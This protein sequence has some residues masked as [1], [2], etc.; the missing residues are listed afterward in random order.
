MFAKRRWKWTLFC[1]TLGGL[2]F[3]FFKILSISNIV[4]IL[5]TVHF[6]YTKLGSFCNME[7]YFNQLVY[8]D[9]KVPK[10][11]VG[12][13][14]MLCSSSFDWNWGKQ[15]D[16]TACWHQLHPRFQVLLQGKCLR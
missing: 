6:L 10:R 3:F 1:T 4:F 2:S 8:W 9:L 15:N 12:L 11:L 7:Y 16:F 5:A 14:Q 13:N